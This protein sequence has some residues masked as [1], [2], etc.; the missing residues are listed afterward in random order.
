MD[1]SQEIE[2]V[3][4]NRVSLI[5]KMVDELL[6]LRASVR[7]AELASQNRIC[8]LGVSARRVRKSACLR[9]VVRAH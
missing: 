1:R 2:E 5:V 7:L 9:R 3:L 8:T 6:E 4:L